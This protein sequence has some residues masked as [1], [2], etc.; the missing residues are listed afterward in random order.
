MAEN[1]SRRNY[2]EIEDELNAALGRIGENR[3]DKENSGDIDEKIASLTV[4]ELLEQL[5][6]DEFEKIYITTATQSNYPSNEQISDE[7]M[8]EVK[9]LAEFELSRKRKR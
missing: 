4:Q 1:N 5:K 8:Q 2:V 7:K 3:N 9:T 6:I